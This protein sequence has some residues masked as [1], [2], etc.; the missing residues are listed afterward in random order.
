M[1]VFVS[2]MKLGDL[3]SKGLDEA[4]LER[5]SNIHDLFFFHKGSQFELA[6]EFEIPQDRKEMLGKAKPYH[7]NACHPSRGG[8]FSLEGQ[9]VRKI[10]R[11]EINA[12]QR[13]PTCV[14]R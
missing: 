9:P 6:V 10:L 5:T 7:R 12:V 13:R 1:V 14:S 11:I 4:I 8:D 3:L 2:V